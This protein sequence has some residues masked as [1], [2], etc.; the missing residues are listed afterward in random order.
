MGQSPQRK[1]LKT[2]ENST[3]SIHIQKKNAGSKNICKS[4]KEQETKSYNG[5]NC[6]EEEEQ[7]RSF[8]CF[9]SSYHT[10]YTRD[11]DIQMH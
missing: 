10:N 2:M 3:E 6:P 7:N 1:I 4:T 9:L 5:Q 11:M 8:P